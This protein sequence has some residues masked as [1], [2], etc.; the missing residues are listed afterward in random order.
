MSACSIL[1]SRV[2]G[3]SEARCAVWSDA[4]TLQAWLDVEVARGVS[5][6]MGL[7]GGS[8]AD[9]RRA[10]HAT[11]FDRAALIGHRVC[12]A[13]F[14]P[15]LRQFEERCGE[16][17]DRLHPLGRHDLEN[18]F[19]HRRLAPGRRKSHLL[20]LVS[21][22]RHRASMLGAGTDHASGRPPRSQHALPMTFSF[23]TAG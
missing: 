22:R 8:G 14:V 21:S 18:I 13:S 4:A 10:G 5:G 20:T 2:T 23:K 17:A 16:S 7:I 1:S 9:H 15:V 3:I 11:A 19:R 6:Q 12:P